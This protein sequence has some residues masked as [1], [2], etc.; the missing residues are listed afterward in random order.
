MELFW[1]VLSRVSNLT[2]KN[3]DEAVTIGL[4]DFLLKPELMNR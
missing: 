1:S 4:I 2:P 3:E